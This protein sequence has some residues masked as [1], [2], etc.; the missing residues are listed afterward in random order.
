MEYAD[1]RRK[2]SA[3]LSAKAGKL[4]AIEPEGPYGPWKFTI[5]GVTKIICKSCFEGVSEDK[6]AD[7]L[8][9]YIN[10]NELSCYD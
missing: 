6:A 9:D 3:A 10:T 5:D 2:L 7:E 8:F 1:Y 4:V